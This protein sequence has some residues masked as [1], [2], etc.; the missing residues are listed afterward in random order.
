MTLNEA[1]EEYKRIGATRDE[2]LKYV[3]NQYPE[4]KCKK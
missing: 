2:F 3:R 4:E 1:K